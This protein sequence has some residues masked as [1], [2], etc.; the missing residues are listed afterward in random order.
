[1]PNT[2][3]KRVENKV[4]VTTIDDILSKDDV[5]QLVAELV[6]LRPSISDLVVI[7][8][9]RNGEVE[10][11]TTLDQNST[12]ALVVRTQHYLVNTDFCDGTEV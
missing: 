7:R 4:A 8:I 10:V 11:S 9:G 6:E 2:N 3:K 12:L 1:M 5:S